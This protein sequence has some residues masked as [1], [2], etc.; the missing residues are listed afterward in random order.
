M[1][2]GNLRTLIIIVLVLF[3]VYVIMKGWSRRMKKKMED[4]RRFGRR[5]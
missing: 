4:N 2:Q 1:E 3:A 5:K